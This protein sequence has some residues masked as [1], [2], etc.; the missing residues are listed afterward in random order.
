MEARLILLDPPAARREVKLS[1]PATIGRSRDAKIKLVHGQVSRVHCEFFERDGVLHVRDLGSTNGTYV[2]EE[3]IDESAVPPGETVTIGAVKFR[4]EYEPDED[5]VLPAVVSDATA[6]IRRATEATFRAQPPAIPAAHAQDVGG[7][8]DLSAAD[9]LIPPMRATEG[10]EGSF[11]WFDDLTAEQTQSFAA[12]QSAAGPPPITKGKSEAGLPQTT[13]AG[14][15]GKQQFPRPVQWDELEELE[16]APL[17]ES[18]SSS[19][20]MASGAGD[21]SADSS[22]HIFPPAD[23]AATGE[24]P[25]EL[26]WRVPEP[27]SPA[28]SDFAFRLETPREETIEP[29]TG[30]RPEPTPGDDESFERFLQSLDEDK[31]A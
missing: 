17:E 14:S 18:A 25:A 4:A 21:E 3:R 13:P 5:A 26:Q 10:K 1:L 24:P 8:S 11:D 31:P 23:D 28:E 6:T 19:G 20:D 2:G 12:P 7:Q 15:E 27:T 22:L 16:L 29:P 9:K 30:P